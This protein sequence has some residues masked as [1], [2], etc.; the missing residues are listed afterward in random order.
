MNRPTKRVSP[1]GF[2]FETVEEVLSEARESAVC[3]HDHPEGI[4]GAQ[5]TAL[6]I[7]RARKGSGKKEIRKE[8]E[9]RFGYDLGRRLR[10]IRPSYSFDE[11]C[12][13]SV[14]EAIISFLES[15]SW[16][17]AVRNAVSLG[18]DAD[19]LACIA[20]GIAEAFYGPLPD[21]VVHEVRSRLP[22]ELWRVVQAWNAKYPECQARA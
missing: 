4:K 15:V 10:E 9:G 12:Q 14:P 16:E 1:V 21:A 6:A 8:I 22:A 5:A 11:T 17:D 3:S 20:G 2:A 13:G 18:G 7:F 19:T